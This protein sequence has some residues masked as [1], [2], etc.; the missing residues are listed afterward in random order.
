VSHR[1]WSYIIYVNGTLLVLMLITF[2]FSTR[3]AVYLGI[4]PSVIFPILVFIEGL[5]TVFRLHERAAQP[6]G[7]K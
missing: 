1:V 3:V 2:H 4:G 7:P 5:I 6:G